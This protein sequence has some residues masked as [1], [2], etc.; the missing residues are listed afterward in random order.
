MSAPFLIYYV[1]KYKSPYPDGIT[2]LELEKLT[3]LEGIEYHYREGI[4]GNGGFASKVTT[5]QGILDKLPNIV[6]TRWATHQAAPNQVGKLATTKESMAH[7]KQQLEAQLGDEF[8][9]WLDEVNAK[10]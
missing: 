4:T 2:K 9:R 6:D 5:L 3:L 8:V 1:S 10:A 7:D